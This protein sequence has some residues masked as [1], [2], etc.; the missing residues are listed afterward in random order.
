MEPPR[1]KAK[2]RQ[3]TPT[4]TTSIA[5]STVFPSD[6]HL[7]QCKNHVSPG[8]QYRTSCGARTRHG[9]VCK[10]GA[11]GLVEDEYLPVCGRHKR[12]ANLARAAK[13]IAIAE[14]GHRCQRPCQWDDDLKHVCAAHASVQLPCYMDRLP[15]ELRFAIMELLIPA[16]DVDADY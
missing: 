7:T 6:T 12:Q 15:T 3:S 10:A 16:G 1:K 8:T 5:E 11:W 2:T 4:E 13:C 9:S 14:C